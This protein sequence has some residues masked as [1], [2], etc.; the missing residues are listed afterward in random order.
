MKA[1]RQ[2]AIAVIQARNTSGLN[3]I[4]LESRDKCLE[5]KRSDHQMDSDPGW[6]NVEEGRTQSLGNAHS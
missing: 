2:E 1:S 5:V 4:S 6:W 3:Q